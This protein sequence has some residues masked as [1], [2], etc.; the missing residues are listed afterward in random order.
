M[1]FGA[2]QRNYRAGQQLTPETPKVQNMGLYFE[3]QNLQQKCAIFLIN[4]LLSQI[5][6][7]Y[8]ARSS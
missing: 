6:S 8:R 7:F 2:A 3:M 4:Q 5:L 1:L